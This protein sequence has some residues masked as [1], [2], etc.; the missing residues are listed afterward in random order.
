MS[1][2]TLM[3]NVITI[4]LQLESKQ[5][6]AEFFATGGFFVFITS[7]AILIIILDAKKAGLLMANVI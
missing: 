5:R 4:K 3:V 2:F 1:I 7:G 6:H